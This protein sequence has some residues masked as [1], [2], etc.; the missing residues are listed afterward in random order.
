MTTE[1]KKQKSRFLKIFEPKYIAMDFGRLFAIPARLAFR[2]KVYTKDGGEELWPVRGGALVVANHTSF[3]DP[4]K[5]Y[6]AFWYRRVFMITSKETMDGGMRS[7]LMKGMGCI[8]ID[9]DIADIECIKQAVKLLKDG[10]IVAIFQ[11]GGIS[12]DDRLHNINQGAV[13]IAMQAG[14]P[15]IP[16]YFEPRSKWY[17]RMRAVMGNPL[18]CSDYCKKRLPGMADIELLTNE[19][20]KRTI[21]CKDVLER[22]K[23]KD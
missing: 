16:M 22:G 6:G 4:F 11:Q 23:G 3:A 19:L 1:P 15:I 10:R 20:L 21:E 17:K 7:V 14:V 12:R 2:F 8:R 13:L 5:I 9:R 18:V